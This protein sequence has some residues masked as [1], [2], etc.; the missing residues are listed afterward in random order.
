MYKLCIC[1]FHIFLAE[2]QVSSRSSE[3]IGL[4]R[5]KKRKLEEVLSLEYMSPEE[6]VYE[7]NSDKE[8]QRRMTKLVVRRFEWHSEEMTRELRR[9]PPEIRATVGKN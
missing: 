7:T 8:G 1:I 2:T 4:L 9:F 3:T 6:S 5:T